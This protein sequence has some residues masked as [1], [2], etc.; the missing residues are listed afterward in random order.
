M[1]ARHSDVQFGGLSGWWPGRLGIAVNLANIALICGCAASDVPETG[2]VVGVVTLDGQPV[3]QATVEFAPEEGRTSIGETNEKGEY[4]LR[5]TPKIAGAK[6]GKHVV[7]IST[8]RQGT[9]DPGDSN[10]VPEVPEK[11]PEKYNKKS[12]LT[13]DVEAGKNEFDF[14]LDSK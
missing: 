14:T 13:E 5:Y 2:E 7:R 12:T 8:Y 4:V 11:F 1:S 6:V 9:G 3:P 10:R